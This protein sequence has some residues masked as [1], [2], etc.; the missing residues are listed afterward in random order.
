MFHF[1]DGLLGIDI[2]SIPRLGIPNIRLIEVS[3]GTVCSSSALALANAIRDT[4]PQEST[5]S[6]LQERFWRQIKRALK[7]VDCFTRVEH[8]SIYLEVGDAGII[9]PYQH[10]ILARDEKL[11]LRR[12]FKSLKLLRIGVMTAD[13]AAGRKQYV[14]RVWLNIAL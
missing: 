13:Y 3:L 14:K 8:V 11:I 6:N 4:L 5:L 12:Q 9:D 2:H 10:W 7:A 1:F